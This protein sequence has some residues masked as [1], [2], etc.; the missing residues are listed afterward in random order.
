MK[1]EYYSEYDVA[2]D[3][4]DDEVYVAIS[5]EDKY[6]YCFEVWDKMDTMF[7]LGYAQFIT[8]L[9]KCTFRQVLV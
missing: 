2:Y 9:P 1:V 6:V 5:L 8:P 4:E 7:F 3:E